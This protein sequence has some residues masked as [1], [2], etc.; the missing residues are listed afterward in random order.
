MRCEI[1]NKGP[2]I[3]G[4]TVYRQNE[5]GVKGIWACK[6]HAVFKPDPEVKRI[7]NILEDGKRPA[8]GGRG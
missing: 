3:D 4:V 2:A 6:Q 1:C 5:K 7:V 8:G